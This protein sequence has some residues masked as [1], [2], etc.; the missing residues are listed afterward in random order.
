MLFARRGHAQTWLICAV[1]L[2]V[3]LIYLRIFAGYWLGDDFAN[4]IYSYDLSQQGELGTGILQYFFI[5]TSPQGSMYRPLQ[6][7]AILGNYG[8][9]GKFYPCWIAFNL[10]I[11]LI[12]TW[13]TFLLVREFA[14]RLSDYPSAEPA[15]LA[16]TLAALLFGLSPA[17]AEGVYWICAR[18]DGCV[19][20]LSVLSLYSWIVAFDLARARLAWWFPGLLIVAMLTKESAAVLPL[21]MLVI[22]LSL[23]RYATRTH[24]YALAVSFF[25]LAIFFVWRLVLFGHAFAVNQAP[26]DIVSEA[27]SAVRV[28]EAAHS[29][30]PWWHALTSHTGVSISFC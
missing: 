21:Q 1:I 3:A 10:A 4:L 19:T 7:A 30:V 13:L 17:I 15:W 27:F 25:L 16:P 28:V 14:R 8:V 2:A 6:V 12:N 24:W 9:A 26:G 11:H 22:T 5:G 20:L 23:R 18:A 29:L